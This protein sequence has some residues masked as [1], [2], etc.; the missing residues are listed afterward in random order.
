LGYDDYA[1]NYAKSPKACRRVRKR[2]KSSIWQ[3]SGSWTTTVPQKLQ[4]YLGLDAKLSDYLLEWVLFSDGS[5]EVRFVSKINGAK[6]HPLRDS[7]DTGFD[8]ED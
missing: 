3:G 2:A 5:L 1:S 6:K 7:R 8:D 4:P